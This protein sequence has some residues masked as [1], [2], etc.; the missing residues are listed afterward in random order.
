M[1]QKIK[2]LIVSKKQ[3][4]LYLFF[5]VI[6]TLASLVICW[7]TILVAKQFWHDE[8]GNPTVIVDILGSTTQWVSGVLIAFFTNRKWVFTEAE[9]GRGAMWKQLGM[10]SG[11]RV[12][13]YFIEVVANLG[14]IALLDQVIGY[15][16]PTLNLLVTELTLSSRLWAKAVSSVIV[17]V[18]NYYISKL[19]VFR[20]KDK[21]AEEA[22]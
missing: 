11:S 2:D 16:A 6:T 13:T 1:I 17:I 5:G 10:F 3:L 19:I 20:K 14:V 12:A 4:I 18:S 15:R 9:K 22:E 8:N 7:L 21:S